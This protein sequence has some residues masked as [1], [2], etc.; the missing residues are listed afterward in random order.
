MGKKITVGV[1]FGGRSGEHNVSLASASS[2]IKSLNKERYKVLPIGI[3]QQGR[4]LS[5]QD[6][7]NLL[8]KSGFL[9]HTDIDRP[10]FPELALNH[11][12]IPVELK[13]RNSDEHLVDV[14]IPM[15]HGTFG[16]DGT[17]QGLLEIANVPY[18][19]SRVLSSSVSM[20]KISAKRI[21]EALGLPVCRYNSLT[22][23]E[24]SNNRNSTVDQIRNH[25]PFPMFVKPS[26][27]GSSVG[28]SKVLN[29]SELPLAIDLAFQY[30]R[31]VIIEEGINAREIEC[32][33]LGNDDL[34]VS[35][36]GEIIP[37]EEFYTYSSKYT[38]GG[39]DVIIPADLPSEKVS[40]VQDLSCQAYRSVDACGMAR[41][42][43]L[44]ERGTDTVYISEIN[45][46]PGFTAFSGYARM[47]EATGIPY[48]GLLDRLIKLAFDRFAEKEKLVTVYNPRKL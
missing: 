13:K 21:F 12:W 33:V 11:G 43:F 14:V 40:A 39:A 16:E 10:E 3:D 8:F 28:I 45:T 5:P 30:D 47:L 34:L 17:M 18:V 2:V 4:W 32:S 46:I 29:K 35:V 48:S 38:P 20:D 19:G 27:S 7:L 6:S 9:S 37:H 41:I 1:M 31:R 42:D 15:L 25:L 44:M 23:H 22:R 24:W 36:P 26:N